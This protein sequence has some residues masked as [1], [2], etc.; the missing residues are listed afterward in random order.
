MAFTGGCTTELCSLTA[1]ISEYEELGVQ[2]LCVSGDNPFAQAAWAEKEGIG[3]TLLSDYE[4]EATAAW[5]VAYDSFLPEKNLPMGGVPKRS[6]FVI[7][8]EG[9]VQY[10]EV[11]DNPAEQPNFE[12]IKEAL[13]SL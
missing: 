1:G 12:A 7:D 3:I 9:V 13:R 10:A 4:H 6:A 11:N 8:S 5:G 2:V